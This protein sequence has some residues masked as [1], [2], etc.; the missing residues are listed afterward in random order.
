M[1]AD[2]PSRASWSREMERRALWNPAPDPGSTDGSYMGVPVTSS[3]GSIQGASATHTLVLYDTTGAYGWLGEMYAIGT[4]NLASH[5]GEWIA[6]PAQSYVCGSIEQYDAVVYLGSSYDEP[7]PDCL[8]ADVIASSRPVIWAGYN[9]WQLVEHTTNPTFAAHYG[10]TAIELDMTRFS[11]VLY[12]GRSLARYADNPSMVAID[13]SDRS[14]AT[15]LATAIRVDGTSAPWAV[16]SRNLTVVAEIP[17][18]YMSEEDRVLCFADLL[19]D[20]LAPST[21]ERHRALVR[22]DAIDPTTDPMSLRAIA[23]TLHAAGM[24][25]D[26]SVVAQYRDPFGHYTSGTPR[27]VGFG[28]VPALV[29]A[30]RYMQEQGGTMVMHGYTHQWDGGPNPF[31]G[32]TG[33][34]TEFS[35]VV[36][37]PD[38]TFASAPLPEDSVEWATGRIDAARRAFRDVGLEAPAIWEFPHDSASANAYVAASEAMG[39]RWERAVYYSGQLSLGAIDHTHS[40]AQMFPFVVRDVYGGVVLPENL[41]NILIDGMPARLPSDVVRAADRQL[42]VRDNVAAFS[43]RASI[44]VENLQASIDGIRALGYELA[45]PVG[46]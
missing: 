37:S 28:D 25:F 17:F 7:L 41:G 2:P 5:F 38:H 29:D 14:R 34:D 15:E 6:R 27:T 3:G 44:P 35:R 8:F 9:V 33:D 1:S 13:I 10:F 19:F 42:V 36:E 31:D 30:L 12:K 20:A 21:P 43:F 18:S 39:S 26:F 45:S 23:D 40:F 4:A 24:P 22:I 11:S 32:V 16:R 46:L